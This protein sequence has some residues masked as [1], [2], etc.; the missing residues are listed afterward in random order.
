VNAV[1]F[2]LVQPG[3]GVM[4]SLSDYLG[5]RALF[6]KRRN[7]ATTQGFQPICSVHLVIINHAGRLGELDLKRVIIFAF[8]HHKVE[9]Q[10]FQE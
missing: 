10:L 8:E 7:Q 5:M 9:W 6:Q 2:I 1:N 4:D 3:Q